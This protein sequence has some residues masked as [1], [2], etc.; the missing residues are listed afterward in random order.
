MNCLSRIVILL[1]FMVSA[2]AEEEELPPPYYY[3]EVQ[4][5]EQWQQEVQE[6]DRWINRL[7]NRRNLELAKA[8]QAQNQGDRLQFQRNQLLDARRAWDK[9]D[10]HREIAARLDEEIVKLETKKSLILDEHGIKS[11]K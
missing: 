3:N 2:V 8:T 4:G 1:G 5:N 7:T 6:L 11:P 9:A 10:T